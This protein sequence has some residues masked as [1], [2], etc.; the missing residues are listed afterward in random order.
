MSHQVV[1]KD[2]IDICDL[3]PT[4]RMPL[5]QKKFFF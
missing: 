3:P 1:P 5:F 2:D 4:N